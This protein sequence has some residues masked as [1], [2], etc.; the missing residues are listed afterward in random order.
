VQDYKGNGAE[1]GTQNAV[2]SSALHP[3]FVRGCTAARFSASQGKGI[4]IM[5]VGPDETATVGP[6]QVAKS[7]S[8][9]RR[10]QLLE[11]GLKKSRS[12]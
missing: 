1:E 12:K 10:L 3:G 6:N 9:P 7:I 5:G 8:Q 2:P 11:P 4:L